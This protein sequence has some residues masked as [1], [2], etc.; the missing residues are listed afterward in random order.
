MKKDL[1][2]PKAHEIRPILAE[3]ICSTWLSGVCK[4][5]QSLHG[6]SYP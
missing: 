4:L 5:L 3:L 1:R 6:F 2:R